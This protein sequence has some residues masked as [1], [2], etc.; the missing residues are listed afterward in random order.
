MELTESQVKIEE[1]RTVQEEL[2]RLIPQKQLE[3]SALEGEIEAAQRQLEELRETQ[4]VKVFLPFS[5]LQIPRELEQPSQISP[6]QLDDIID[7][8]RCSISSFMPVYVDIITSGQSEKEWLNVFQ[9]VI[10][11]LVETPDKAC[12]KVIF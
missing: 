8:S 10:P 7:Y 3:L 2:Q 9:E 11:N 6:N 4:N 1:I 12:I 5:P